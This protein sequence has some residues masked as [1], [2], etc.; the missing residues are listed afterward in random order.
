MASLCRYLNFRESRSTFKVPSEQLDLL[1]G[2]IHLGL[3]GA[4]LVGLL[5]Y[6]AESG[7]WMSLG[8]LP[9]TFLLGLFTLF[10]LK[11]QLLEIK[12]A[13]KRL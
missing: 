5:S 10:T 8:G 6:H 11:P 1:K 13:E 9:S 12:M 4:E 7:W 3:A 2:L